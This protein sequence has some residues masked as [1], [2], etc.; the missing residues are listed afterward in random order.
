MRYQHWVIYAK[1]SLP[2]L[3]KKRSGQNIDFNMGF[4]MS[5]Q[6]EISGSSDW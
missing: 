4:S 2:W 1:I 6:W 5:T 3:E